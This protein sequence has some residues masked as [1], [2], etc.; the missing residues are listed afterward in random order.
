MVPYLS[1]IIVDA[2][3]WRFPD[4]VFQIKVILFGALDKVVQIGNVGLMV[5]GIVVS[6]VSLDMCG[7]SAS[8]A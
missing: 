2:S 7:S 6:N 4:D 5:L 3:R 1:E 8:I